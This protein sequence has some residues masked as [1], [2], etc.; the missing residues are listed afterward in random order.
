MRLL[1]QSSFNGEAASKKGTTQMNDK[2]YTIAGTTVFNGVKG[3][4]FANGKMNLRVNM[5][6]HMGHEQIT[7]IELPREMT[8]VQAM[9]HL[10]A[11]GV[12][13]VI[14]TRSA[15]KT[16]KTDAVLAAEKIAASRAKAAATR[17]ANKAAKQTVAA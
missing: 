12:N 6:K 5:L 1:K 2:A 3:Y 16:R 13:A 17:A 8:R 10:M 14:P 7:L 11:Q 9:A 4:R 15:D